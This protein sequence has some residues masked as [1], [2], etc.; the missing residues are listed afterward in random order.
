MAGGGQGQTDK[1]WSWVVL[2]SSWLSLFTLTFMSAGAGIL[3]V[4][5]IDDLG[6]GSGIVSTMTSLALGMSC[7]LGPLSGVVAS[8]LSARYAVFL[9]VVLISLGMLGLSMSH[10]LASMMFYYAIVTGVGYGLAYSPVIVIVSYY[11]DKQRM[12]ANGILFCAPGTA[13]LSL[14]YLIRYVI[15]SHGWRFC[16]ALNG[17]IMLHVIVFAA[18]FFPTEL[19]QKS[20][21]DLSPLCFWRNTRLVE[22][23]YHTT[24]CQKSEFCNNVV[25]DDQHSNNQNYLEVIS[26]GVSEFQQPDYQ[27]YSKNFEPLIRSILHLEETDKLTFCSQSEID[28]S[29]NLDLEIPVKNLNFP[30]ENSVDET[31][32]PKSVINIRIEES[33]KYIFH[34]DSV[35]DASQL[36]RRPSVRQQSK[37]CS[38][39]FTFGQLRKQTSTESGYLGNSLVWAS[40]VMGSSMIVPPQPEEEACNEEETQNTC[41]LS[42]IKRLS[43]SKVM[44]I[45]NINSLLF[46]FGVGIHSVHFP[47]YARS[48]GMSP[49]QVSEFFTVYGVVMMAGRLLGGA[50]FNRLKPPLVLLTFILQ[51]LNGLC[52]ALAPVYSITAPGIFV[53]EAGIALFYGQAYMLIS[54]MLAKLTGVSDLH[55]AFGIN[56]MFVGI[57][58]ISAPILAGFIYD[59]THTYDFPMVMGGSCM[60]VGALCLIAMLFVDA[61]TGQ[62]QCSCKNLLQ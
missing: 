48:K 55:I 42:K 5:I 33:Q 12:L 38:Q 53:M 61:K 51:L 10:S 8:L 56:H 23:K 15:D 13:L 43:K 39:T 35:S 31:L 54:P 24:E 20:M 9:G 60:I 21:L 16:T 41:V 44:W 46:M 30:P 19:E 26:N 50:L 2:V 34:E 36:S 45:L 37:N 18:T 58:Y 28:I 25:A 14:P 52:M 7:L 49:H 29:S 32:L 1:G 11:F 57:G 47:A 22:K 17:A 4:E 27:N 62:T 59:V 6:V 3:Q 40:S